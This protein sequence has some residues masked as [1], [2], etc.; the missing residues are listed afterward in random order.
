MKATFDKPECQTITSKKRFGLCDHTP[1]P[2][3]PAYL[4]ETEGKKWIAVVHNDNCLEVLFTAIDHCILL[5]G[6]TKPLEK[7][8]DAMLRT[9]DTVIFVELKSR[10][11]KGSEWVK[12]GI[13]QLLSTIRFFE[14]TGLSKGLIKKAYVANNRRP[15]F[16][17]SQTSRMEDFRLKT[18][19]I[20]RIENRIK[21]S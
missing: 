10:N 20:L 12:E 1:P 11:E 5:T 15:Y 16:R 19:Y 9:D 4:D 7:S 2:S 6:E 8:C 13:D 14:A 18:G 21:L 17:E 3:S